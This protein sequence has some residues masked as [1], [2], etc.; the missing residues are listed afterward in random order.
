MTVLDESD[1]TGRQ[2]DIEAD[3]LG[4]VAG[5]TQLASQCAPVLAPNTKKLQGSSACG[6]SGA[7]TFRA[8]ARAQPEV[9]E[10]FAKRLSLSVDPPSPTQVLQPFGQQNCAWQ[11][12]CAS[13]ASTYTRR[14]AIKKPQRFQPNALP[15]EMATSFFGIMTEGSEQITKSPGCF[16]RPTKALAATIFDNSLPNPF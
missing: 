12:R 9:L 5:G 11:L 8:Q 3:S 13:Q 10:G 16:S 14:V 15:V 7:S 2:S 4:M 1:R 6:S